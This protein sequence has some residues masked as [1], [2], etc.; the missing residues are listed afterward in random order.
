[1]NAPKRFSIYFK[2]STFI[3]TALFRILRRSFLFLAK[4]YLATNALPTATTRYI[5]VIFNF[6]LHM[7]STFP[8]PK[9]WEIA[10]KNLIKEPY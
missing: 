1:M 2:A 7:P 5:V 6:A 3:R 4:L 10:K 9:W 8:Y